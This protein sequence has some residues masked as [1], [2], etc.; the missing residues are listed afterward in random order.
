MPVPSPL[1]QPASL[2]EDRSPLRETG[3]TESDIGASDT[4]LDDYIRGREQQDPPPVRRGPECSPFP[5]S[6]I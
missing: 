2:S 5:K 6:E 1:N 4:A 3:L